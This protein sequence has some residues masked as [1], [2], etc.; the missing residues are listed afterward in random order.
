MC[1]QHS[2][3][4]NQL[5]TLR[6]TIVLSVSRISNLT[7]FGRTGNVGKTSSAVPEDG[8]SR[9]RTSFR[10]E[11]GQMMNIFLFW[12]KDIW[13]TFFHHSVFHGKECQ[14]MKH[15]A[16]RRRWWWKGDSYYRWRRQHVPIWGTGNWLFPQVPVDH[17]RPLQCF[18]KNEFNSELG[19]HSWR[20]KGH[21]KLLCLNRGGFLLEQTSD[22]F[23]ASLK[24]S[25]LCSTCWEGE[26]I[27]TWI[28]RNLLYITRSKKRYGTNN[29]M[30]RIDSKDQ[31]SPQ[32]DDTLAMMIGKES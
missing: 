26:H 17:W 1:E 10:N 4:V 25:S 29:N 8:C 9:L 31:P 14:Q 16:T 5:I 24:W 11:S 7:C 18:G 20:I 13:F 21:R 6:K 3:F 12:N 19:S 27:L 28:V 15:N 30:T 23:P 2:R 22:M 32:E